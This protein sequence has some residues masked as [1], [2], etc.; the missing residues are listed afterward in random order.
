MRIG[1]SG[2]LALVTA[3]CFLVAA[4]TAAA[5]PPEHEDQVPT[6]RLN[7]ISAPEGGLALDESASRTA[8]QDAAYEFESESGLPCC[9]WWYGYGDPVEEPLP[10][11]SQDFRLADEIGVI[12]GVLAVEWEVEDQELPFNI[13]G[14]E[15]YLFVEIVV[16]VA[17]DS[18]RSGF[19]ISERN[20]SIEF[21]LEMYGEHAHEE[22]HGNETQACVAPQEV[23]AHDVVATLYIYPFYDYSPEDMVFNEYIRISV[24]TAG[25]SFLELPVF[26]PAPEP[27]PVQETA[28]AVEPAADPDNG[29]AGD[30]QSP[31]DDVVM[32]VPAP[33]LLPVL[34]GALA[35]LGVTRRRQL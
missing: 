31:E 8:A 18:Y 9:G 17:C 21:P 27:E 14:E 20:G 34:I 13:W 5:H 12:E 11:T 33:G 4:A 19:E 23:W 16:D 7:L 29:S 32:R 6:Q 30:P 25:Q 24:D 35:A 28:Q 1:R 15:W 10:L 26:E 22:H 3:A 2:T